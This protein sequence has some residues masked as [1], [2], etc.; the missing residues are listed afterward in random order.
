MFHVRAKTGREQEL[1]EKFRTTSAEV[2]LGE[3]GNTG[4]FFGRG[5]EGDDKKLLFASTWKNLDAIKQRFGEG[6]QESFLPEGYE[7]LIETC[8]V[9]HIQLDTEGFVQTG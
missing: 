8:F 2:V 5:V 4:Y 7:D 6:W 3:P 9:E 1:L